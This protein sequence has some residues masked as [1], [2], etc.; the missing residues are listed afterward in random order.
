[1][2]FNVDEALDL[3]SAVV[4]ESHEHGRGLTAASTKARM[5]HRSE[6]KFDEKLVGFASFR[7]FLAEAQARGRV[8]VHQGEFDLLITPPGAEPWAAAP[9]T[10]SRPGGAGGVVTTGA[11][12]RI[13]W[14]LWRNFVDWTPGLERFYDRQEKEAF[15]L[16]ARP[17]PRERGD[18]RALREALTA[19]PA[20]FVPIKPIPFEDQLGWMHEF[21]DQ[22]HTPIKE[23]LQLAL[24]SERPA[25]DFTAQVRGVPALSNAWHSYLVEQVSRVIERWATSQGVD[26]EIFEPPRT[27][28]RASAP[29]GAHEDPRRGGSSLRAMLHRAIDRMPEHELME[30]SLPVGYLVETREQR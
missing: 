10:R 21:T 24:A 5:R 25:R 18:K 29:G 1:M 20:R 28:V 9:S 6:Q 30:I 7:A 2:T 15:R 26:T 17:S 22:Q 14:H 12:R 19:D 13:H 16:P 3:L 11:P 27:P 23:Q 8:T 4:R